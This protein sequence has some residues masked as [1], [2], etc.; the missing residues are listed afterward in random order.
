MAEDERI[1]ALLIKWEERRQ[2]G[3]SC[4]AEDLC[5]TDPALCE[6]LRQRIRR[7]EQIAAFLAVAADEQ[8]PPSADTSPGGLSDGLKE[9]R[10]SLRPAVSPDELGRLG[11]Y[12]VLSLLG[13]GGMGAVW[14]AEDV[15]L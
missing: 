9:L 14:R 5:P 10:A 13:K 12:R 3:W 2:Q 11:G 15:W 6:K 4:T 1:L 7:R 8:T